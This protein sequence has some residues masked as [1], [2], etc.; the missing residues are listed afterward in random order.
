ML[1][2][3]D[4]VP[5]VA[6]QTLEAYFESNKAFRDMLA[7]IRAGIGINALSEVAEAARE[8]LQTLASK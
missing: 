8:K 3:I 4:S 5:H 1:L 2:A 6:M 7:M